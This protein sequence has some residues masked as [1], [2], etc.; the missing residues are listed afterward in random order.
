MATVCGITESD[1][2]E[3]LTHFHMLKTVQMAN[4]MCI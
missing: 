2:T 1:T 3:Q 4:F